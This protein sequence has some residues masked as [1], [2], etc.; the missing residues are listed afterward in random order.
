MPGHSITQIIQPNLLTPNT[1]SHFRY[2][3]LRLT[4]ISKRDSNHHLALAP[5]SSSS[6]NLNGII[7]IAFE[8][9]RAMS[10]WWWGL[11]LQWEPGTRVHRIT[12]TERIRDFFDVDRV[13]RNPDSDTPTLARIVNKDKFALFGLGDIAKEASSVLFGE[14]A[15]VPAV[16]VGM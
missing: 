1:L 6:I 10:R 5:G 2:T 15:S 13:K 7:L 16:R 8:K 3:N 12:F 4:T 11:H 14:L 9:S